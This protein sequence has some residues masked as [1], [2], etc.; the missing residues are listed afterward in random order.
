MTRPRYW[1]PR[2]ICR[3]LG[4]CEMDWLH[5]RLTGHRRCEHCHRPTP[6]PSAHCRRALPRGR[7]MTMRTHIGSL[8]RAIATGLTLAAE[9]LDPQPPEP[10]A[11]YIIHDDT[12]RATSANLGHVTWHRTG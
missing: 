12:N 9:R 2:L 4:T 7:R 5:H 6:D 11:W 10:T 1:M 8:L 3:A